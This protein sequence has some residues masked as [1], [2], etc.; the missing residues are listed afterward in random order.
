MV[1]AESVLQRNWNCSYTPAGTNA[2]YSYGRPSGLLL[3]KRG[4]GTYGYTRD[5][6]TIQKDL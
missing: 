5:L 2:L 1:I 6:Y 4:L 3:R